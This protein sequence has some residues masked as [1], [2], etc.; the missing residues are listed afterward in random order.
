MECHCDER[1]KN[2]SISGE[3]K[4]EIG[5][6][7]CEEQFEVILCFFGAGGHI[8]ISGILNLSAFGVLHSSKSELEE[9][10]SSMAAMAAMAME[11]ETSISSVLLV[12]TI[13]LL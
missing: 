4:K 2:S 9:A 12:L 1:K 7:F 13:L 6:G 8:L 5:E 11:L 3:A 10:D